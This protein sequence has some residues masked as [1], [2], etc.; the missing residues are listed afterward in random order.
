[1]NG[2]SLTPTSSKSMAGNALPT[3]KW[4]SGFPTAAVLM[5]IVNLSK[6]LGLIFISAEY[7]QSLL[8]LKGA[9]SLQHSREWGWTVK[10]SSVQNLY[11]TTE[12]AT[13]NL[14]SGCGW[15]AGLCTEHELSL[16]VLWGLSGL[17]HLPPKLLSTQTYSNECP[18]EKEFLRKRGLDRCGDLLWD[19]IASC[20]GRV[21][22]RVAW[23]R[24]IPHQ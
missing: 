2:Q 7:R 12:S 17:C 18:V 14:L 6:D 5:L 22:F 16:G 13:T 3:D 9:V 4:R 20:L 23:W 21:V 24:P 10:I 19:S 1:M 8:K 11:G 15:G